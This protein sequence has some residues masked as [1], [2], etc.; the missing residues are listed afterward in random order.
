MGVYFKITLTLV[1]YIVYITKLLQT[2]QFNIVSITL[3]GSGPLPS[4]HGD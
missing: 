1:C 3:A 4:P 2:Q